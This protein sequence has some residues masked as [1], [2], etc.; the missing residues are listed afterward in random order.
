MNPL[1]FSINRALKIFAMLLASSMLYGCGN[2]MG[3]LEDYV[4]QIKDSP[5]GEV[6]EPPE[7]QTYETF[8]YPGHDRD[9][10]DTNVLAVEMI[11]VPD[12][13]SGKPKPKPGSAIIDKNRVKEYLEGYPLDSLGM[14][15]TLNQNKQLWALIQT[16]DGTIQR[17]GVGNYMGK[18]HGKITSITESEIKLTEKVPDRIGGYIERPASIALPE[19]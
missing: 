11:V 19:K 3:E 18:N 8:V 13:G 6:S 14:V 12:D 10:F 17:V 15:G 1:S 4:Q 16:S 9:P 7:I 2:N 5:P